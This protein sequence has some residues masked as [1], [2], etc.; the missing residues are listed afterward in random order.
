MYDIAQADEF[1]LASSARCALPVREVDRFR[2]KAS[3]PG[4][5]TRR[6][7]EAFVEE[8]GFDFSRYITPN[9]NP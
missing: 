6:L 2:P 4:P 7:M 3:V 5:I 1:F 9:A 8:T